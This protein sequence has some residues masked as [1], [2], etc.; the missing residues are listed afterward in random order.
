MA[1]TGCPPCS[2]LGLNPQSELSGIRTSVD[3]VVRDGILL[4][5]ISRFV[6]TG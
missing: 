2:Q 5:S 3:D 6:L 1:S 4:E